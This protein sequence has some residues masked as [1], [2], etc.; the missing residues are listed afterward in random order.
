MCRLRT[1]SAEYE[2]KEYDMLLTEQSISGLNDNGMI[3]EILGEVATIED[4]EHAISEH[5]L[6]WAHRVEVQRA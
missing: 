4:I 3:D 1:K 5:V 6:L 2:C